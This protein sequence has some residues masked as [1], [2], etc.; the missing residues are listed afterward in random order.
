MNQSIYT[1]LINNTA[2]LLILTVLYDV[3][4]LR[5]QQKRGFLQ[6]IIIVVCWL[7]VIGIGLM[8]NPWQM[9]P[10]YLF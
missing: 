10:G 1:G 3:F 4:I 5:W 2:L 9:A 6:Q 8:L 7:P